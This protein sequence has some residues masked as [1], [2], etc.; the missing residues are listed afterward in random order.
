MRYV[1]GP[2]PSRR[3]GFSPGVDLVPYK[4]CTLELSRIKNVI[5][6][7]HPDRVYLNTVV[8]PPSEI[9]AKP[10]SSDEMISVKNF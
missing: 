2:V 3:L 5:F 10:L 1:Y 4:V 7:I 6:E 8:R 9:Y